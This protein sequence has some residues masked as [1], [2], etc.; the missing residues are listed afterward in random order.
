[1]ENLIVLILRPSFVNR[2]VLKGLFPNIDKR[3]LA[4]TLS[5]QPSQIHSVFFI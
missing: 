4:Q 3:F 5:L 1:M 2:S